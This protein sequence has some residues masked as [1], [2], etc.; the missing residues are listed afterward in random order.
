MLSGAGADASVRVQNV[1]TSPFWR[2]ESAGE[3][4]QSLIA[5]PNAAALKFAAA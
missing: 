4:S 5:P 1:R 3:M 2:F